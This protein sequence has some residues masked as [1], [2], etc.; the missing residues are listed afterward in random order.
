MCQNFAVRWKTLVY[1]HALKSHRQIG[2]IWRKRIAAGA[3][4]QRRLQARVQHGGMEQKLSLFFSR[5][6]HAAERFPV[7]EPHFFAQLERWAV[8]KAGERH[9]SVVAI[10]RKVS[11]SFVAKRSQL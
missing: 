1:L 9:L 10:M 4:V 3:Q 2:V 11:R 8:F 7:V 5:F 6:P